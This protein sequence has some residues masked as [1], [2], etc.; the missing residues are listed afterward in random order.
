MCLH[1][2]AVGSSDWSRGRNSPTGLLLAVLKKQCRFI[3]DPLGTSRTTGSSAATPHCNP[4]CPFPVVKFLAENLYEKVCTHC[5]HSSKCRV[6][7]QL[8]IT[9]GVQVPKGWSHT[10]AFSTQAVHPLSTWT[11]LHLDGL[12]LKDM[13]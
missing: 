1:C 11:V 3:N 13:F 12:V 8:G 2:T 9:S 7:R 5:N 10:L 6:F 4:G